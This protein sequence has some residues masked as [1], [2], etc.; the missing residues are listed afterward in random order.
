MCSWVRE[1]VSESIDPKQYGSVKDNSR[2]HALVELIHLWQ[3]A[4]DNPG[5]VLR[6]LLLDY[7]KAF[8]CVDHSLLL[9]KL[10]NMG[11]HDCVVKWFT[12]FLCERK[13]RTKIGDDISEWCTINA[14]VPQRTLFGPVGF[15]VHINDLRTRLPLY[16]YVDNSTAWEVCSPSAVDS[17]IQQAATEAVEWSDDNLM[18]VNCDKTKELLVFLR[19]YPSRYSIYNHQR[20]SHRKS[21][22]DQATGCDYKRWLGV[23]STHNDDYTRQGITKTLLFA[24]FEAGRCDK[25]LYC[26]DIR[27]TCPLAV[28]IFLPSVA[29]GSCCV[30]FWPTR[31][32]TEEGNEDRIPRAAIRMR[33]HPCQH[34]HPT[35]PTWR[36]V[37]PFF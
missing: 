29:H 12:S 22:I 1:E 34:Q 37:S 31:R 21:H 24:S 13:Q 17:Q 16:K 6:V 4:L 18:C 15:I 33:P 2:V 5:K 8:D 25:Q 14:G 30:R 32:D 23:W 27:L 19:A 26:K 7:S 20:E 35:L 3:E 9:T 28:G 11:V 36:P 10:A